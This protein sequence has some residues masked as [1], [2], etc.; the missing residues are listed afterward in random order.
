MSILPRRISTRL[1]IV[2]GVALA[3]AAIV[4]L[5]FV[6]REGDVPAPTDGIG[7]IPTAHLVPEDAAL[8]V[9]LATDLD[10]SPWT[11]TFALLDR[12]GIEDPLDKVREGL[13]GEGEVDWDE[14]IAPFLGAAAVLFVSSFDGDR[15][16]DGPAGAVIFRAR[17]AS[18]AEAV[19]LSRRS[20]GFDERNYRDIAYKV[21]DEGGVLAVI[22]DHFIYAVDE[23]TR[24]GHRRHQPRRYPFNR[25]LRRLPPPP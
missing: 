12:L 23:T 22:G 4:V 13:E 16:D 9:G 17:D 3:V 24:P 7:D 11:V 19:I 2:V 14:E 1:A 10:S 5:S 6:L 18:A 8:Y 15:R 25:G 21:M 20:D